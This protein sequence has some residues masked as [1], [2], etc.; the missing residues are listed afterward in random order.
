[1]KCFNVR[2]GSEAGQTIDELNEILL[3]TSQD[4]KWYTSP[5][6]NEADAA[7]AWGV[8]LDEWEKKSPEHRGQMIELLFTN[9]VKEAWANR[10]RA[11]KK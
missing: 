7:L 10:P 11:Q 6:Y 2:W 4:G 3:Q 1:M 5:T 8:P 9:H